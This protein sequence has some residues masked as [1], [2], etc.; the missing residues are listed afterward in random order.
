MSYRGMGQTHYAKNGPTGISPPFRKYGFRSFQG[1][2]G[3]LGFD[4]LAENRTRTFVFSITAVRGLASSS[5]APLVPRRIVEYMLAEGLTNAESGWAEGG[6][7]WGRFWLG[8]GSPLV[9]DSTARRAKLKRALERA[10]RSIGSRVSFEVA[11]YGRIPASA[12]SAPASSGGVTTLPAIDIEASVPKSTVSVREL[13]TVLLSKGFNP[14]TIDG[15]W[16]RNTAGAL[17]QASRAASAPALEEGDAVGSADKRSVTLPSA[18]WAAIRA[19]PNRAAPRQ[20]APPAAAITVTD[21][22]PEIEGE[23]LP[24]WLP[25]GIG[26][27]A[28]LGVGGYFIWK[29]QKRG[30]RR[31]R[32]AANRRGRKR[33]RRRTSR[34]R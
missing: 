30:G 28:L 33:R 19:L 12:P 9:T 6:R 13:Q 16:G 24:S 17:Q 8:V 14:G 23:G 11:G 34:R 3:A 4:R 26:A 20:A 18:V 15:V 29:G 32:V 25:W 10:A 7:V 22:A 1:V 21:I 27:A 31:R 2:L 5:E